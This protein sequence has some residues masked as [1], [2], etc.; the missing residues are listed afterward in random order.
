MKNLTREEEDKI[1]DEF[2]KNFKFARENYSKR[3]FDKLIGIKNFL[4]CLL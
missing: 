3:Q 4:K 2:M 1:I